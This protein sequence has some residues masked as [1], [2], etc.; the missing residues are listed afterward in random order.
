MEILA[1]KLIPAAP[2]AIRQLRCRF[3]CSV[4]VPMEASA[5][6]PG[7]C[8]SLYLPAC[9][10]SFGDS[11]SPC[12]LSFLMEL[13][14]VADFKFVQPFS[15]CVGRTDDFQ[16]LYILDWKLKSLLNF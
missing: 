4:L 6:A 16:V 11:D 8:D 14:T 12:D 5:C 10:S 3:S 13:R 2:P 1:L 7:G 9:L 15:C